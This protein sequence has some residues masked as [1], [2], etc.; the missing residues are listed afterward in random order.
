MRKKT[1]RR[2]FVV[3]ILVVLT[4]VLHG[5]KKNDRPYGTPGSVRTGRYFVTRVID[6]DTIEVDGRERVRY[7]GIDTPELNHPRKGREPFG[8]EA[9]EFNKRLVGD[10]YVTLEF[11]KEIR[12]KYGRLLA[13]VYCGDTFVNAEILKAG[14]ARTLMIPPNIRY[15]VQFSTIQQTAKELKKGLW[16]DR[17]A[18]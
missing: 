18:E 8:P 12:D 2:L 5:Q 14:L 10:M 16:A 3:I 4:A 6:G 11:D 13:Y 9:R 15:A 17:P 1:L 7:I